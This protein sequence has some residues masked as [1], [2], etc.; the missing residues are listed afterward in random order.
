MNP[1]ALTSSLFDR[2][3]R[4]EVV[5]ARVI[6]KPGST[7]SVDD[8]KSL[9]LADGKHAAAEFQKFVD[10]RGVVSNFPWG[11][12]ARVDLAR[13]YLLEAQSKQG[14]DAENA[15]SEARVAYQDFLSMWKDADSD[16]PLLK[17][18]KAEY[19]KLK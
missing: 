2:S 1:E 8:L 4:G 14:A 10:Q 18:A 16:I 13:A 3:K 9:A 12:V 5:M 15:R 11:A 7:L 17:A 6:L 19:A